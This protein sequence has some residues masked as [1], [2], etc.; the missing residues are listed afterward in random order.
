MVRGVAGYGVG[1]SVTMRVRSKAS[2]DGRADEIHFLSVMIV[3]GYARDATTWKNNSRV[4]ILRLYINDMFWCDFHLKDIMR[5][6]IFELPESLHIYPAKSGKKIP[7]K[8]AFTNLLNDENDYLETPV[9]QMELVFE[10]RDVYAGD[11][12]DDTCITGIAL[13]V[14]GGIY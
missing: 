1:E 2:L 12:F 14:R 7:A 9:Y 11:K 5:P 13:D 10:I 3:N 6:Q 4:K 8:G